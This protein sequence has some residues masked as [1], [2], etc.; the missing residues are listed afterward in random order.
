MESLPDTD[1]ARTESPEEWQSLEE[2]SLPLETFEF[3]TKIL[4]KV[5]KA[6]PGEELVIPDRFSRINVKVNELQDPKR[7]LDTG[8]LLLTRVRQ[9]H[10]NNDLRQAIGWLTWLFILQIYSER[11]IPDLDTNEEEKRKHY[12]AVIEPLKATINVART[13]EQSDALLLAAGLCDWVGLVKWS[14]QILGIMRD[15]IDKQTIA[16]RLLNMKR[17]PVMLVDDLLIN[18]LH[19]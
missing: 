6:K 16:D 15:E 2:I 1:K 13:A 11:Y 17:E 18:R 7:I 12:N 4:R 9:A 5:V 3:L 10:D 19:H 14:G 8:T